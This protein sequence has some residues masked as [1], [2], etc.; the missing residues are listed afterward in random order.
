MQEFWD[1]PSVGVHV[2]LS[3]KNY[4]LCLPVVPKQSWP[5]VHGHHATLPSREPVRQRRAQNCPDKWEECSKREKDTV[6]TNTQ[7]MTPRQE[8]IGWG[9]AA[10]WQF[11]RAW[12]GACA[13]HKQSTSPWCL[14]G[15]R[16]VHSIP[17]YISTWQFFS[18]SAYVRLLYAL[19]WT[20]GLKAN[21]DQRGTT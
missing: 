8:R 13:A 20:A 10:G 16:K 7:R 15:T 2:Y 5:S 6:G 9:G 17:R 21:T 4:Q 1:H 19:L 12:A 18:S 3:A 14:A 11:S